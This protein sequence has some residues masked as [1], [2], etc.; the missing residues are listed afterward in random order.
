MLNN[1]TR[2]ELLNRSRASQFPGSIMEV[3]RAAEQGIDL[4]SQHEAQSQ[5]QM[6]V[7]DTPQQQ[8]QGLREEH[9]RGNTQ[10]SMA[11]PNVQPNQS[12]NTEGMAA[13]INVDK[14]S[15]Q[16]HLVESYKNVPPG[17]KNLPTGPYEGTVIETPAAYQK[18]GV[19]EEFPGLLPEVEVS[20]LKDKSYNKLS[21]SQKQVYDSFVTPG[22][23]AQTVN[24]GG[25]REMHW[26]N[27]LQMVK[28]VDVNISNTPE[29][30][31]FGYDKQ[32][33]YKEGSNKGYFRSHAQRI[34]KKIHVPAHQVY[35]DQTARWQEGAKKRGPEFPQMSDTD[36]ENLARKNYFSNIIAETAHIP[37]FYRKESFKNLPISA[38]R[39]LYR[40]ITGDSDKMG[41][42]SNY[43]DPH[44]I[45]YHTHTGPDSFEEKLRSK[46]EIKQKGGV[47]K[48]HAGGLYH[49]I[50]HKKKSGT[51]RSKSKST[52]SAKSYANMESGFKKQEGGLR[53]H[54]M[55]Y[56]HDTGRDTTYVN[57]VMN[58]I[59][60]HESK[61]NPSQVQISGNKTEGFYEGPGRG[62]YQ[63][64]IGPEKGGNTAINRTANF[65]KHNT[66]KN[67]KDFPNLNT[68]Y[69][70][71]NSLDFTNLSKKDQDALFIGDK[72]F[73]GVPRRNAFDAVTRNRTT[74]PSQEETFNYWLNNHKGKIN[75]KNISELTEKE[76][77]VERKKWNSRT[78]NMFKRG[79][80]EKRYL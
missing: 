13:P 31:I 43:E 58:A 63:Y 24:I 72:I 49:N 79:G 37:E 8:E 69:N 39:R 20:A 47:K 78:K 26:K 73:G 29:K 66:D 10:A 6:Q 74:P 70:A 53:N 30:N 51:S 41:N 18:G 12:F 77:D 46:Y 61:G 64:E 34:A 35:K 22:G 54:M 16:G 38:A 60:Q 50:N 55:N 14:Y 5:E 75:G 23:T 17:I 19:K 32:K 62:S 40:S 11:F 28:D 59:G 21:D 3:Y 48:Y 42:R 25:D 1:A 67:I 56:L 7:A 9:A 80:Y 57:T 65:L 71:G 4:L 15:N 2:R 52:I 27:A 36:V 33:V 76:I 68:I 44:D 45:E